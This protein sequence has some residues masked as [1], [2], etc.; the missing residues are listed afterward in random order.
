VKNKGLLA[1]PVCGFPGAF[2]MLELSCGNFDNS[3]LYQT[4]K[5]NTCKQCGHVY[6]RLLPDEVVG[7]LKYYDQE[8]APANL[9]STDKI[10]DRPGSVNRNTLR[11]Y[12]Q[13]YAVLLKHINKDVRVLD[14]GCAM[15]GFLDYLSEKGIKSLSGLDPIS[16]YVDYAKQK[17]GYT[18]KHGSA[19]AIPFEDNSFDLLIMDQVLEHLVDPRKAFREARR[20]LVEGGLLCVGVPDAARY[21]KSYFFDFFWFLMREHIQHFDAEH[22]KLLAESE[23]F[24]SV[25]F[26]RSEL[27]M[28]SSAMILPNLTGVFRV[29]GRKQELRPTNECFGLEKEIGLYAEHELDRLKKRRLTIQRLAK[30]KQPVYAWGIGREFLYLYEAAGLKKCTLAGLIDASQYKQNNCVLDGR[31]IT[32]CSILRKATVDAVLLIT[33]IA[34]KELIKK[35]IEDLGCRV[36]VLML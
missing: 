11:R 4:V 30:T 8:Y 27:P 14:I 5:I 24:E 33:A 36:R 23:G 7:L 34:Y 26:S 21:D 16:K 9:G 35:T 19:E 2:N 25:G 15:G 13:L 18:I 12:E 20:V 31:N 22:L 6:N 28:M 10:G 32:D 1:C 17:T 3:T 29:T